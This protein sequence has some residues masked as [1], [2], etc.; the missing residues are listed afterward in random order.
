[1]AQQVLGSDP[2]K[3]RRYAAAKYSLSIID[4]VYLLLLLG[5]CLAFGI[6]KTFADILSG[7]LPHRGTLIPAYVGVGLLAYYF[8]TLPLNFYGSFILEHRFALSV[9]R[10]PDW[11]IDQLKAGILVYSIALVLA[12]I[13]YYTVSHFASFWWLVIAAFWIFF[14]VIFAHLFPVVVIPFFFKYRLLSDEVLKT[15]IMN[16]SSKMQVRILDCFEID[17]SKKT[18]KA[19]AAFT[20]FGAS[21][22][23][24]LADT[25][26]D[27]YTYDEIEVILAHEFAHYRLRH[28]ARLMAVDSFLILLLFY[29][30]FVTQGY[31]LGL[32]KIP[33]LSDIASLPLVLLYFVVFETVTRPLTNF[34]S[35]VFE[36]EADREALRVTG[37]RQAFISMMEKLAS[38]NLADRNPHPLIKLLFFNHPPVDERI[39]MARSY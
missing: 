3:A 9:Q 10:I 28:L 17:F 14:S 20:G 8:L 33:A 18:L 13:F 6:P 31:F 27:R 11:L 2:D 16:L 24:I 26:K 7:F 21:K 30:I 23:V 29:I 25:L 22:R 36:R 5:L 19:N 37:L 32:F 39:S 35:R 4:L 1:M 15:R 34:I 12:V 38:Q